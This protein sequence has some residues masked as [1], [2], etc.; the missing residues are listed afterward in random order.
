MPHFKVYGVIKAHVGTV[1]DNP[2]DTKAVGVVVE[3][4]LLD[5]DSEP[6]EFLLGLFR[7]RFIRRIVYASEG[8]GINRV[9]GRDQVFQVP[10]II[11]VLGKTLYLAEGFFKFA[12]FRF[13]IISPCS[14]LSVPAQ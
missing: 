7:S 4:D 12:E 10:Q 8:H 2:R 9:P 1:F 11:G 3:L 5:P 6:H 14:Y 13:H